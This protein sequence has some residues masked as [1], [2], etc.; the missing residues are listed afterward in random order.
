M[1]FAMTSVLTWRERGMRGDLFSLW[2]L[3]QSISSAVAAW[4][5]RLGRLTCGGFVMKTIFQQRQGWPHQAW[6]EEKENIRDF[7]PLRSL[8]FSVPIP[9]LSLSLLLFIPNSNPHE[10]DAG[11]ADR[12]GNWDNREFYNFQGYKVPGWTQVLW[13]SGHVLN[14]YSCPS[15]VRTYTTTPTHVLCDTLSLF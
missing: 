1:P 11:S 13:L 12:L 9:V 4:Y 6:G 10:V 2:G 3:F 5:G 8:K 15:Q 14:Q 7:L